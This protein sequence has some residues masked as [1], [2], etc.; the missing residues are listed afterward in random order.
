MK[1]VELTPHE[2]SIIDGGY[3]NRNYFI[4]FN[5]STVIC[6]FPISINDTLTGPLSYV[7]Y[8]AGA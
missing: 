2:V 6:N 8:V 3:V 5:D 1:T 4:P 7:G